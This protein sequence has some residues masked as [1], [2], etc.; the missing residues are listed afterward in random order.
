MA[1]FW[2]HDPTASAA[3]FPESL[4]AFRISYSDLA[5]IPAVLAPAP[6]NLVYLRIEGAEI[7]A[8]PDEYFQ[9]WA[10]VTAIALN[11]I[12]LTE[13]PLALGANMAQLEWLE[14]RGNNITTIPPQWLS[15]QKQL[16]VVDLSGNGL[17]DGPWYLANRGVALELSSNPITTLTS[18]IDPSLL[19][20]RTIVLDE[21]PFCTANPSSACQPKCA[22]M[23]ETKMIGNGKCD[24]PCYSPKCQ[25]DGGDCDSFGFDRRN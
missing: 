25:F 1:N 24:W 23:C 18:S 11:E 8:I 10:S 20:K 3:R 6:P 7:S 14:L 17:V 19:Q 16:V 9:A 15:Q 5:V 13:I 2:T 4:T 21:S 22:H 12:K